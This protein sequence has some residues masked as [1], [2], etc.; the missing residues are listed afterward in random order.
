M[1]RIVLDTNSLIQ[2]IPTHSQ[3]RPVWDS[4]FD[5]RNLLCVSTG[6]LNEYEEMLSKLASPE[7]AKVVIEVILKNPYTI[8]IDPRFKLNLIEND[9]DDNMFVDCAFAANAKYIVTNDHHFDILKHT[10]F[11]QLEVLTIQAFFETL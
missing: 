5:G 6:I 2:A 1:Q 4:I 7:V 3:Y 11:P 8:Y 10:D 9:P